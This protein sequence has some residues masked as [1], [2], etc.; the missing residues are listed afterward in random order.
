MVGRQSLASPDR[1]PTWSPQSGC[2]FLPIA[3]FSKISN[4]W[5]EACQAAAKR[6]RSTPI[7]RRWRPHFETLNSEPARLGI[8]RKL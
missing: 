8:G 6:E 1:N 2:P 4:L 7:L 3:I 5:I